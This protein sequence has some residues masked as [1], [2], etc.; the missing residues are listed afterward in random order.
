MFDL[1]FLITSI[2]RFL[3]VSL[4][5]CIIIILVSYL[6]LVS[7]LSTN[8]YARALCPSPHT[9]TSHT[10]QNIPTHTPTHL[11]TT[12]PFKSITTASIQLDWVLTIYWQLAYNFNQFA[13]KHN[14]TLIEHNLKYFYFTSFSLWIFHICKFY[15]SMLFY[16]LSLCLS[17]H[18]YRLFACPFHFWCCLSFCLFCSFPELSLSPSILQRCWTLSLFLWQLIQQILLITVHIVRLNL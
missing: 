8:L 12:L 7:A 18:F 5:S 14:Q 17:L 13:H 9:H 11:G 15:M 6:R 1:F 4:S 2:Y 10:T 16:F 3:I